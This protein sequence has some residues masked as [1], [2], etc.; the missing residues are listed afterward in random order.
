[1]NIIYIESFHIAHLVINDKKASCITAMTSSYA[2]T[3]SLKV[4]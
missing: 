3:V 1:M 2:H 4:C